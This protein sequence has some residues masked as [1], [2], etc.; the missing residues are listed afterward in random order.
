MFHVSLACI[1]SNNVHLRGGN[2]VFVP[3][4]SS[5]RVRLSSWSREKKSYLRS[6]REKIP[7]IGVERNKLSAFIMGLGYL[8]SPQGKSAAI[9][10]S[11]EVT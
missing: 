5:I 6:S 10:F 9:F 11:G 8:L 1:C 3:R 2:E 7:C 4:G